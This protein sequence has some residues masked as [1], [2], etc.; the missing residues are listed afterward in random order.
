MKTLYTA[1]ATAKGGREGRV[2]TDDKQLSANLAAYNT[3]K[4]GTNP[5]QLFA[6]GY[7]AC[8]GSSVQHVAKLQKIDTGPVEVHADVTLNQDDKGFYLGVDLNVS[9]PNLDS[10]AAEK[11][12]NEAHNVCPYSKA[13]HGNIKVKLKANGANLKQAA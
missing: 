8:F 2:E 4:A 3:G 6:C 13:T 12:V 7:A 5:E 10:K 11:L 9:V 1:H